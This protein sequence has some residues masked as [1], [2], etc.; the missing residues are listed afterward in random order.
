M[1]YLRFLQSLITSIHQHYED[2]LI[3]KT[4]F[5]IPAP[6]LVRLEFQMS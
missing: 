6:V 1:N 5:E 2:W 4:K 3:K